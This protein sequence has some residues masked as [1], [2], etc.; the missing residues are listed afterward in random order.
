M[1]RIQQMKGTKAHKN[2]SHLHKST[3]P[4]STHDWALGEAKVKT[5]ESMSTGRVR[6]PCAQTLCNAISLLFVN[7]QAPSA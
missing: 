4:L 2:I 3:L 6:P 1:L 7:S 5:E